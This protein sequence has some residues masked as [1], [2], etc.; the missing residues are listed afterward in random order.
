M[1]RQLTALETYGVKKVA[2]TVGF[3]AEM[4][5][6]YAVTHFSNMDFIFVHNPDFEN[7][8]TLYSLA[9]AAEEI[10]YRGVVLQLNGDVVFDPGV[11]ERLLNTDENECYVGVKIALCGKEEVKVVL[12]PGNTV[13]AISKQCDPNRAAGEAVGI[14]KFSHVFWGALSRNLQS[15]KMKLP[16]EYFEYAV[17]RTI[18]EG[19]KIQAFNIA[20]HRAMEID[21]PADLAAARKKF[22]NE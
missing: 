16:H 3:L 5:K 21:F 7:T 14:N 22:K 1:H 10:D 9:L 12:A 8:N 15:L 2:I 19:A 17:E 4:V 20:P 6:T 11:I 13:S 18:G